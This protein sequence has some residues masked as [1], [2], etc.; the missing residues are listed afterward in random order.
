M[1]SL[2]FPSKPSVAGK[3]NILTTSKTETSETFYNKK[4][5]STNFS[6]CARILYNKH[7]ILLVRTVLNV[8]AFS[9]K[10]RQGHCIH[11][12]K[13]HFLLHFIMTRSKSLLYRSE[14]IW[15]RHSCITNP[16]KS[17]EGFEILTKELVGTSFCSSSSYGSREKMCLSPTINHTIQQQHCTSRAGLSPRQP[18]SKIPSLQTAL[19]EDLYICM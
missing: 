9:Q 14:K 13:T 17:L 18:D 4:S 15:K 8:L 2:I 6:R 7:L 11:F 19:R 12:S 10:W 3:C 16:L 5:N 1:S